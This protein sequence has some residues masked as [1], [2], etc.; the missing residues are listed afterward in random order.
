MA[1][2]LAD[3]TSPYLRQHQHNPVDWYPWGEAAFTRA[4]AEDRPILL[5]VGYSAC[6]WCHVMAHESFEDPATA[7]VMNDNYVNIKVDREERPDVDHLYMEA[8]QRLTGRG[9]WPMTVFL[10]PDGRPF[11]GGTYFPPTERY[12]MPSFQRVLLA[13]AAAWR[14]QR[15][16]VLAQADELT[17]ALVP[18]LP[19]TTAGAI[20]VAALDAATEAALEQMDALRGGLK[21]APKFPQPMLLEF[22]LRQWRRTGDATVATLVCLTLDA[23]ARGGIYDQ[24]GGGFARYST[25]ADWLVPHFEK[26]LYDNAQ[27]A[28]LY[29]D[30]YRAFGTPDYRRVAEETLDY[31]LH[32][33]TAPDG[34]FYSAQDADSEGIE[35]KFY[36]WTPAEL[37]EALGSD[38]ARIVGAVLGVTEAGN[39]EGHSILHRPESLA[40]V[41]KRFDTTPA[42]VMAALDAAQPL[43]YQAR[44]R[45]VWP[46]R[47]DKVLT[48]WNGLMLR[49][50]A[51]AGSALNR[52]DYLAAAR[53]N[54]D[55][56]LTV[57][58]QS[59]G[60]LWRTWKD[61]RAHID[62]FLEDYAAYADG[63]LSL[64]AATSEERYF[65]AARALV[66]MML[67][68]FADPS[69]AGF[70]DT[71][72]NGERL[73]ARPKNLYDNAVPAGNSIA[74]EV[75]L[76]L[77]ALTGEDRYA[78]ASLALLG[79]LSGALVAHPTAFGRLLCALDLAVAGATEVAIV[80]PPNDP[81][82]RMMGAVVAQSYLPNVVVAW[83]EM[84][85]PAPGEPVIPLL[86]GRPLVDGQAAAYVCRQ[87]TCR[88]PVTT[89]AALRAELG[90]GDA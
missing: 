88:A 41:A 40:V 13:M 60:R 2:R 27:L 35:G 34:G 5:S 39:F 45:R 3:E 4:A 44:A 76:R 83:R 24:I 52:P 53:R 29:L 75:L 18:D 19:A 48:S 9:G 15:A 57:L 79:R 90:L 20:E 85:V 77:A 22:L 50:F 64:A 42:A 65:V 1:N 17:S 28:R 59:D 86:R 73:I 58:R 46:G 30:A 66:D 16:A 21:G 8:V 63:L 71:A 68:L 82:V 32:E 69:D 6:H 37:A 25:D 10:T 72:A 74:A 78:A 62:G 11:Y 84:A 87:F 36:I 23:M 56:V 26:M 43:L 49:A 33:M 38:N 70:F 61:G 51:E 12:G 54:A 47:D 55:F 81:T 80:G 31:V 7:A 14:D 67:A 89:V